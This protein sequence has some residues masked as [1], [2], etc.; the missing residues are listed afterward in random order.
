MSWLAPANFTAPPD[1][2]GFPVMKGEGFVFLRQGRLVMAANVFGLTARWLIP[3]AVALML[4]VVP[5]MLAFRHFPVWLP[6]GLIVALVGVDAWRRHAGRPYELELPARCDYRIEADGARAR[7]IVQLDRFVV[8]DGRRPPVV[9][10]TL[11]ASHLETLRAA[12]R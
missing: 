5:G 11:D 10:F 2:S 9:E 8:G 1:V 6:L 12:L 4:S 7:V 3:A